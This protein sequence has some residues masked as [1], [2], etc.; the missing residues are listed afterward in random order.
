MWPH[1]KTP[2]SYDRFLVSFSLKS[3][4][5]FSYWQ[6]IS[7]SICQFF[8]NFQKKGNLNL[9]LK[10]HSLSCHYIHQF[11]YFEANSPPQDSSY[12]RKKMATTHTSILGTFSV[13]SWKI[14]IFFL[15]QSHFLLCSFLPDDQ[16]HICEGENYQL[17]T[18]IF[19]ITRRKMMIIYIKKRNQILHIWIH[20]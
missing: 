12:S 7:F 1:I 5:A 3:I 16:I 18:T 13:F 9:C 2:K 17:G 14:L 4:T 8:D 11:C 10:I 15:C 19:Q 6:S 20:I